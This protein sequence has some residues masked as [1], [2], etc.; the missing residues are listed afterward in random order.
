MC[1]SCRNGG[2]ERVAEKWGKTGLGDVLNRASAG[3]GE[4]DL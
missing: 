3:D 1:L 4:A 2:E